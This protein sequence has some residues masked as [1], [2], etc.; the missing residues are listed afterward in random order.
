MN[1]I[2]EETEVDLSSGSTVSVSLERYMKPPVDPR[3]HFISSF[4][5]V[6][7]RFSMARVL[8]EPSKKG[9]LIMTAKIL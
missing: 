1:P 9:R 8:M 4:T 7:L 6:P 5:L 3:I 2:P